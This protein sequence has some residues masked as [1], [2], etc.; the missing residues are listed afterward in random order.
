M[1]AIIFQPAKSAMQSGHGNSRKWLL[2]YEPEAARKVEPLMGWTE[3]SD[4]R[5]QVS[6]R[7]ETAEDAVAYCKKQG[8]DYSVKPPRQRKIQRKTYADNFSSYSVR[9]PGTDPLPRP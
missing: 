9:G 5:Q 7:F 1:K 8:I 2:E 3:S 6:M 4:M